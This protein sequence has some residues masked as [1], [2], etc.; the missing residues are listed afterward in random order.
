MIRPLRATLASLAFAGIALTSA[1]TVPEPTHANASLEIDMFSG[2]QKPS[3][4]LDPEAADELIAYLDIRGKHSASTVGIKLPTGFRGLVV[5]P[6]ETS[7]ETTTIRV[8]PRV[9]YVTDSI[10]TVR[11]PDATGTAFDIVWQGARSSFDAD[12]VEAVDTAQAEG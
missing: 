8:L 1:C 12:V 2:W 6:D 5:T 11:I 7:S 10:G 4:A 9:I 3:A